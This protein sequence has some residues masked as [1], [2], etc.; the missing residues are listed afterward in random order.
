MTCVCISSKII[1]ES[2]GFQILSKN[3]FDLPALLI[4]RY[5]IRKQL[6]SLAYVE[7]EKKAELKNFAIFFSSS[8]FP[9]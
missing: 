3:K 8:L 7:V 9:K 4:P 6:D 2:A 1:G 5:V